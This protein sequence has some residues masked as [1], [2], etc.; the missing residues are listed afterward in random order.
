MANLSGFNAHNVQPSSSFEPLPA[1]KYIASIVA[2]EEK[3]TKRGDGSF[4]EFK[5]QILDGQF[6]GRTLWSR[7]NISNPNPQAVAI[8]QGE[9]SAICRAVGVMTPND[10]V[11]LHD[12][13]LEL[14][15]V[16]KKDPTSGEIR[17]EIKGYFK[18][19]IQAVQAG[20]VASEQ[21]ATPPW[22]RKTA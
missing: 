1:G 9:L 13:P 20:A 18:Q 6:K 8:A 7:L 22:M 4:I 10:S 16:C 21:K 17:N 19:G 14:N 15:V 11:E 3:A 2:S 12:R 5:F